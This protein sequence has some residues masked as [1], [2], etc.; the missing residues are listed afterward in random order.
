MFERHSSLFGAAC[1][2]G[3]EEGS[4]RA[5][6]GA[7]AEDQQFLAGTFRAVHGFVHGVESYSIWFRDTGYQQDPWLRLLLARTSLARSAEGVGLNVSDA[8]QDIRP[9]PRPPFPPTH[10]IISVRIQ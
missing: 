3:S 10:S 6:R 4:A 7:S 1:N 5:N 9:L 8:F 2:N